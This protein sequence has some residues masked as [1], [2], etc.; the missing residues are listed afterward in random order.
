MNS[1][2]ANPGLDQNAMDIKIMKDAA[3]ISREF[4]KLSLQLFG[5][6]ATHFYFKSLAFN[7]KTAMSAEAVDAMFVYLTKGPLSINTS[8]GPLSINTS[9]GPY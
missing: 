7:E 1:R 8:K 4:L 6:V 5:G 3:R 9:K 2:S